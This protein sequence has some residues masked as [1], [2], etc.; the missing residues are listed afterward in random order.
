MFVM[1]TVF[2]ISRVSAMFYLLSANLLCLQAQDPERFQETIQEFIELDEMNP[3]PENSLL[4]VGS[5]SIRMWDTLDAAFPDYHVINR[6]FGG[7]HFSDAIHWF[8]ALFIPHNPAVIFIYEGDND[9]ASGKS[10]EMILAD[11]KTLVELVRDRF[12]NT[13]VVL[14]SPKPA[15]ARWHLKSNYEQTNAAL[16]AYCENTRGLHFADVWTHS[17]NFEGEPIAESFRED[18]IHMNAIGYVIWRNTLQDVLESIIDR[19]SE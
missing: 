10:A 11:A 14:I 4:F 9:T 1:K 16:E 2:R 7:S 13:P 15:P 3:S 12:E 5:S 18:E 17:L 6:G 19:D 8:D